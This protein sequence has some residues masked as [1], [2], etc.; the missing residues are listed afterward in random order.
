MVRTPAR[1]VSERVMLI[2]GITMTNSQPRPI[3]PVTG[4]LVRTPVRG[5]T[6]HHLGIAFNCFPWLTVVHNAKGLGVKETSLC[7]FADGQPYE[8]LDWPDYS[9]GIARV[10]R[11]R[12]LLGRP[13]D[14][15][16]FNCEHFVALACGRSPTSPQLRSTI[17]GLLLGGILALAMA[18]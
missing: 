12:A 9:I 14:L 17:G 4:S 3:C 18:S 13:Y 16:N 7:E 1:L 2:V 11:A 6:F 10:Q 8:I 5:T 15:L